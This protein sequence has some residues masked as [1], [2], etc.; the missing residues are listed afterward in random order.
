MADPVALG[1]H[2]GETLDAILGG[3]VRVL[4]HER[5]YRFSL[6]PILL[7]DFAARTPARSAADLGTGSGVIALL[8]AALGGAE[9][10]VG[11][12]VQ[13]GM[14]DLA[15]RAVALNGLGDRVEIV[16]G[17][18][19]DPQALP[20]DHFELVVSNP[21]FR[22]VAEGPP[23]PHRER[24]LARTEIAATMTDVIHTTQ[25]ILR[26]GGRACFVYPATRLAELLTALSKA[27]L[28][29]RRLRLVHPRLGAPAELCLVE[30]GKGKAHPL[31]VL[32]TLVVHEA[33]GDY[34]L[35][36]KRIL[37]HGD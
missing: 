18:L 3:L 13:A 12:E 7:A 28:W 30:A 4:Q 8:L 26:S 23:S 33:N 19:R 2:H 36:L 22:P 6:D 29:P 35:E 1:P 21:P 27:A 31:E 20:R 37:R 14:A 10:V 11:I 25:R 17:D 16:Q 5:G 9:H 34:T 15:R 24:A 32:P